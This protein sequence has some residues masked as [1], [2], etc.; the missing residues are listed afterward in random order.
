MSSYEIIKK[1]DDGDENKFVPAL[2]KKL[3]K[4]LMHLLK[5]IRI[6]LLQEVIASFAI[7]FLD[8]K[9]KNIGKKMDIVLQVQQNG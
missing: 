6:V 2:D 9:L 3:I 5:Q 8:L 7:A 1:D 4:Y